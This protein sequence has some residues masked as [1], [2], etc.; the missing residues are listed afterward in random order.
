[1]SSDDQFWLEKQIDYIIRDMPTIYKHYQICDAC[2]SCK[3]SKA[4]VMSS[5]GAVCI[6]CG[7]CSEIHYNDICEAYKR[8]A[9]QFG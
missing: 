5:T 1:M 4:S 8:E 3:Y 6:F 2:A 9:S 7:S